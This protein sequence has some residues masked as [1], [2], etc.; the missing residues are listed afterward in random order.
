MRADRSA[1][2]DVFAIVVATI[3]ALTL[4]EWARAALRTAGFH[5]FLAADLSFLVVPPVLLVLLAPI[6]IR[7]RRFIV[8]LFHNEA[9]TARLAIRAVAIGC[10][11][12]LAAWSELVAGVS[13]GWHQSPNKTATAGPTF[14]F[15]CPDTQELLLGVL[16]MV[17]LVPIIEELIFRGFILSW[18]SRHGPTVAIVVSAFLFMLVHRPSSW[19]F[20]F[21][22]G[23]VFGIQYWKTGS[24]WAPLITHATVNGLVQLDWRCLKGQWNPPVTELPLWGSGVASIVTFSIAILGI[25]M[26]LTGRDRGAMRTPASD[27]SQRVRDPFNDV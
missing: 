14:S 4:R 2:I 23:M 7:K 19:V 15:A 1:R 16:V 26:L 27:G 11:L 10:L 5:K 9:F 18:L 25:V 24:L 8:E 20:V 22:A 13:F 12:R 21:L 17:A 6:V 3:A